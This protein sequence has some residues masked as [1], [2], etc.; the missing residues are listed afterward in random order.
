MITKGL[1]TFWS[2]TI[3]LE[4]TKLESPEMFHKGIHGWDLIPILSFNILYL[5]R[6]RYDV[7]VDPKSTVVHT[8]EG[9]QIQNIYPLQLQKEI[10]NE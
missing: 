9:V 1:N 10:R 7:E 8:M 3:L 2:Q 5:K 4:L 6:S